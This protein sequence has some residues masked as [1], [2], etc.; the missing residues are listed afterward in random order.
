[1]HLLL[2]QNVATFKKV[3]FQWWPV[4]ILD[5]EAFFLIPGGTIVASLELIKE[6]GVENQQIKVVNNSIRDP[7]FYFSHVWHTFI[8]QK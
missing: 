7:G 5:F 4:T 2:P 6:R 8:L 3:T 1:L